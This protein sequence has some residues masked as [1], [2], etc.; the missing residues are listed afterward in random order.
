M[1]TQN[2]DTVPSVPPSVPSG[3]GDSGS[4]SKVC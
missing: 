4:D 1:K 2:A 3:D